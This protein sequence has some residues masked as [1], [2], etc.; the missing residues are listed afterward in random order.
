MLPRGSSSSIGTGQR[1]G[2]SI[3]ITSGM[4]RH[5]GRQNSQVPLPSAELQGWAAPGNRPVC[6]PEAKFRAMAGNTPCQSTILAG[7]CRAQTQTR[8]VIQD[9]GNAFHPSNSYGLVACYSVFKEEDKLSRKI[10][11]CILAG[12]ALRTQQAER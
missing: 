2:S 7:T 9:W 3:P 6:P 10:L 8:V 1:M 5:R 4:G 12:N 11:I